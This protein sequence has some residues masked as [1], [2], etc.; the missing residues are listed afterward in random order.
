MKRILY[1]IFSYS[2]T[3][4]LKHNVKQWI[5]FFLFLTTTDAAEA[6]NGP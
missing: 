6:E 4:P 2:L 3:S 1:I 5:C